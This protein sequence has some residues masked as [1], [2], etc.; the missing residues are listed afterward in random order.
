[1][2]LAGLIS[3]KNISTL[4]HNQFRRVLNTL[5]IVEASINRVRLDALDLSCR[6]NDPD[7]GID[8]KAQ[9]PSGLGHDILRDGENVLQYKSGRISSKQLRDEF[10]KN[11]VQ[12]ALRRGACYILLVG[13]DYNERHANKLRREL[14]Q[15]CRNRHLDPTKCAIFFGSHIRHAYD[16]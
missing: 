16:R 6:D 13:H 9:W 11:G 15:L 1:M 5:L 7:G 14:K 2:S 10:R 8:A 12:Q 3:G 4:E